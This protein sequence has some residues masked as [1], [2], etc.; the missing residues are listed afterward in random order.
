MTVNS[1]FE[2][3]YLIRPALIPILCFGFSLLFLY[4]T[5]TTEGN[6]LLLALCLFAIGV[7]IL[8]INF[9]SVFKI[10]VDDTKI[11]KTFFLTRRTQCILYSD[12]HESKLK[13]VTG[14]QTKAGGITTGYYH[15]VFKLK[16][17]E[18]FILTP[19]HFKNY[20]QLVKA[21]GINRSQK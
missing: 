20:K 8:I 5:W 7:C 3:F 19:L 15:C 10:I 6:F 18:T 21:I 17:G 4:Q 2:D 13:F 11:I 12:I 16:N 14:L 1:K 9:R